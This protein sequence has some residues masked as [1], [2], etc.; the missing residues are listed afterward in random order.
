MDADIKGCLNNI[1]RSYKAFEHNGKRMTK[2]EVKSVLEYGLELGY[3]AVSQLQD[4]DIKK[5]LQRVYDK[6]IEMEIDLRLEN[7]EQGHTLFSR[8]DFSNMMQNLKN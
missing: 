3:T 5:A 8:E 4:R 7:L 2:A 6:E 1:D